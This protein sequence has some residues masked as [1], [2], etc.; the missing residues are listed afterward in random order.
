MKRLLSAFNLGDAYEIE[1]RVLPG[2]LAVV[3]VMVCVA[4]FEAGEGRWL[5]AAGFGV[6]LEVFFAIAMSKVAHGLG[7]TLEAKLIREW[8]GLPTLRWLLPED[9]THSEQQ[10]SRWR[11]ALTRI[12]GLD[13]EGDLRSGHLDEY[14]RTASDA[15]AATRARLR[16]ETDGYLLRRH[17]AGYG[18]ARNAAG[19]RWIAVGVSVAIALVSV[20]LVLA[21]K[22]SLALP[23]VS[24]LFVVVIVAHSVVA[25]SYVRHCADR[26]AESFF[27]AASRLA[28]PDAASNVPRPLQKP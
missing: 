25:K 16:E 12:S 13:L 23:A 4:I 2:A 26:Y 3:P 24:G 27:A 14:A 18:F 22:V 1:A 11:A 15:V 10:K 17:N 7:R 19:M 5:R 8:G 9:K 6:G 28:E 20:G 21:G